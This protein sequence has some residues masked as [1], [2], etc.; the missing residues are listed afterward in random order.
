VVVCFK[1]AL[2]VQIEVNFMKPNDDFVRISEIRW[3]NARIFQVRDNFNGSIP[4][5]IIFHNIP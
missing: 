1:K 5:S 3:K 4:Y 2:N